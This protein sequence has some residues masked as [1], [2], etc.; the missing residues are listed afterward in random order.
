MDIVNDELGQNLDAEVFNNEEQKSGLG[1]KLKPYTGIIVKIF[2]LLVILAVAYY[3]F[4]FRYA[5]VSFTVFNYE[6]NSNE[7]TTLSLTK[8]NKI[9]S[10]DTDTD[11]KLL[12][13][14]Y[15]V[16]ILGELSKQYLKTK[17]IT[18]DKDS[19]QIQIDIYPD[20]I[21]NI[22]EFKLSGPSTVYTNQNVSLDVSLKN[23]GKPIT[24][25]FKGTGDL[26]IDDTQ[27]LKQGDNKFTLHFTVTK[28]AN[29]KVTGAV[30][31]DK[32]KGL[33]QTKTK[34]YNAIVKPAPKIKI[35][36]SKTIFETSAGQELKIT[37]DLSNSS[38]EA[39]T[40]L[41]L[42]FDSI[43]TDKDIFMSYITNLPKDINIGPAGNTSVD[44]VLNI[45][46]Q[47]YFE[48]KKEITFNAIFANSFT[49]VSKKI[50]INYSAPNIS[51]PKLIDFEK[52]T[53]GSNSEKTLTIENTTKYSIKITE[54][55]INITSQV[56]N[57]EDYIIKQISFD[58]P[59]TLE[60]GKTDIKVLAIIPPVFVSDTF[61][62]ELQL[63]T[64]IGDYKIPL[65]FQILGI[66]VKLAPSIQTQYNI[67]FDEFGKSKPETKPINI[68]NSGNTDL[69]IMSISISNNCNSFIQPSMTGPLTI[70]KGDTLNLF[71]SIKSG[72][73]QTQ[74]SEPKICNFDITYTDPR[75]EAYQTN[76][77][78]FTIE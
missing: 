54:S 69:N 46:L 34:D 17:S 61:N 22:S 38:Q 41:N 14:D 28:K 32:T 18:V 35:N 15:S 77:T 44:L 49:N 6:T 25:T 52:V 76:T 40:G 43:T 56:L 36:N 73:P 67:S 23:N 70:T 13:G 1:N 33:S 45:P 10:I 64:D 72:Q 19:G 60:P 59:E 9:Y 51:I 27:E 5:T 11:I 58:V 3:F 62:A 63:T 12:P 78:Q 53:A 31:L 66:D 47:S 68:K 21:I 29:E 55:K 37:F 48:G 71:F 24:A 74:L 8:D 50:T 16:E 39:I 75:T 30:Y 57:P 2:I 4:F 26:N 20:W 42:N 65:K 7:A